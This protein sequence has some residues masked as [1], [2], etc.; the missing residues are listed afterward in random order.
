MTVIPSP[1][2]ISWLQPI[3]YKNNTAL[4]NY[5]LLAICKLVSKYQFLW[6][7][8]AKHYSCKNV[9]IGYKLLRAA[10]IKHVNPEIGFSSS[11]QLSWT[12]KWA[13]IF[14]SFLL[15]LL[16]AKYNKFSSFFD[17]YFVISDKSFGI[18]LNKTFTT[19]IWPFLTAIYNAVCS[20]Y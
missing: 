20:F 19:F 5:F 15:L 1:F 17:H 18:L 13:I 4:F 16:I 7:L 2:S 10:S 12:K 9:A 11:I 8:F 14:T 3:F 6:S